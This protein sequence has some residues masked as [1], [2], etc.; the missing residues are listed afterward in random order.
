M[1]SLARTIASALKVLNP[2]GRPFNPPRPQ[3]E[4]TD[5]KEKGETR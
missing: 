4:K 1:E 5:P 2:T 3:E